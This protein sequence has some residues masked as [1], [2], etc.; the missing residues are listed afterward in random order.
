MPN[1][2]PPPFSTHSHAHTH[3]NPF[4][5]DMFSHLNPP[6]TEMDCGVSPTCPT[7]AIPASTTA[8]TAL[9]RVVKPPAASVSHHLCCVG[10]WECKM[11]KCKA[12]NE[13]MGCKM[14]AAGNHPPRRHGRKEE[15]SHYYAPSRQ[16]PAPSPTHSIGHF[17][18]LSPLTLHFDRI[19][20]PLLQHA[21]R[22]AYC[23]LS[24]HLHT[25][26]PTH[27]CT[28]KPST[29][30]LVHCYM[31][32]GGKTFQPP[33]TSK[34]AT[35]NVTHAHLNGSEG[36]VPHEKGPPRP[37]RHRPAVHKHL[38]QRD[39]QRGVVPMH[40]HCDRIAHQQHVDASLVNL[41]GGGGVQGWEAGRGLWL[42]GSEHEWQHANPSL[43]KEGVSHV[44]HCSGQ[45]MWA[46]RVRVRVRVG[47]A[48]ILRLTCTAEG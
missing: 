3:M 12:T 34:S 14:K 25:H 6:S 38:V 32:L 29:I 7:T 39:W 37:P 28:M 11:Q 30:P 15:S 2:M 47:W 10:R 46:N 5:M 48:P 23:F 42:Q 44:H 24:A 16:V 18:P 20:A 26:T 31:Q 8:C 22:R 9:S 33:S 1:T 43:G 17:M 41:G 40:H 19:H 36:E 4:P 35:P 27:T 13:G 21:Y 45:C